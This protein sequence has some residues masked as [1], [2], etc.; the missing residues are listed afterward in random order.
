MN[1]FAEAN[2]WSQ[3]YGLLLLP[4]AI[5]FCVYSLYTY[6]RRADMIRKKLP[7]PCTSPYSTCVYLCLYLS[8]VV[9]KYLIDVLSLFIYLNSE[10]III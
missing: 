7:G 5:A 4:V 8:V 1:R 9:L 3:V 6:M 2:A 10:F